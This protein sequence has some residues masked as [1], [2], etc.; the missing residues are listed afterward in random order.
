LDS[1]DDFAIC[2]YAE[3]QQRIIISKDEDYFFFA[4]QTEAKTRLVWVRLGNCRTATLLETLE[5]SWARIEAALKA[6]DQVIEIR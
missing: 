3:S 2:K 4:K 6:G 1:V 5:T